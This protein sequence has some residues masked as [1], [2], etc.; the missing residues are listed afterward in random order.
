MGDR[1]ITQQAFDGNIPKM[2]N[3]DS[4]NLLSV[5]NPQWAFI[6]DDVIKNIA[7][8]NNKKNRYLYEVINEK[9]TNNGEFMP[10]F[11]FPI[12]KY[13]IIMLSTIYSDRT[14]LP[15]IDPANEI[16]DVTNVL[17]A[18]DGL[19]QNAFL[20]EVGH[21][22]VN[23]SD[24]KTCTLNSISVTDIL[25]DVN[26][27]NVLLRVKQI[28]KKKSIFEYFMVLEN[29][30]CKYYTLESD[31]M[32]EAARIDWEKLD[33]QTIKSFNIV[34]RGILP[35][36]PIVPLF[37]ND[38][39]TPSLSP[40]VTADE[41]LN[42]L[43]MFGLAG[44]PSSMLV[45]WYITQMG[46][47]KGT[48]KEKQASLF[49]MLEAITLNMS[50]NSKEEIGT[51]DTGNGESFKNY[52]IIFEAIISWLGQMMG[53]SKTTLKSRLREVRQSAAAGFVEGKGGDI[54][55]SHLIILFNEF[56]QRLFKT[57]SKFYPALDIKNMK[58]I[59]KDNIS[60]LSDSGDLL[61]YLIE[62]VREKFVPYIEAIAKQHGITREEAIK[63]AK[64]IQE[65]YDKYIK[66]DLE[67]QMNKGGDDKSL[68]KEKFGIKKGN[69]K[70]KKVKE[71]GGNEVEDKGGAA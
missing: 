14:V 32:G 50:G 18:L 70:G 8:K 59:D 56:E 47:V 7:F 34:Y 62:G 10:N 37:F 44:M 30:T 55:R 48:S 17:F 5:D 64:E 36:L 31:S 9:F 12:T 22:R 45:K 19:Q 41:I 71:G 57:I 24:P 26:F 49:D 52:M 35:A 33:Q 69:I 65:E 54:Y 43:V 13:F 58:P 46:N 23:N 4:Q 28:P 67:M 40:V 39:K 6:Q 42:I 2:Q 11:N 38:D 68:S 60:L 61:Q 29:K 20:N 16:L 53:I 51:V 66:P 25:Y 21:I 27:E 15:A 3:E 1:I 63:K